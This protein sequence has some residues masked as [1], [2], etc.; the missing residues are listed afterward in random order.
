[1]ALERLL[2]VITLGFSTWVLASPSPDR[3]AAMGISP[4][5]HG[6]RKATY[7][8]AI[9][10]SQYVAVRDGTRLAVD[11]YRPSVS[12]KA[13]ERPFP[14]ILVAS[15]FGARDLKDLGPLSPFLMEILKRGYVIA[16]VQT[17]GHGASFGKAS[18]LRIE[19]SEDYWDLY[20]VI[21]W[22]A[23][24]PW[25]DA[26]VGMAGC[27]NQGVTQFRAASVMPPHL[28]AIAPTSAPV[29]WV[30]LGS[31]N[32]VTTSLFAKGEESGIASSPVDNDRDGR[33]LG[34]ALLEHRDWGEARVTRPYRDDPVT[35]S[36]INLLPAQ[37]WNFL[38][39]FALAKI[40]VFQYTGWRDLFPEQTLALYRSLARLGGVPQK[41]VIGPWYH[42]EWYESSLTDAAAEFLRWYD[43][44]LKGI[45]NGLM[46]DAP[47]RYYVVGAP[48]G[49]EWRTAVRWPLPDAKPETYF[50]ASHGALKLEAA[51]VSESSDSYVVQYAETTAGLA[52]RWNIGKGLP[53]GKN[54]GQ[55]PIPTS[56]LDAL[57]L[58]YTTEP[59]EQDSELTGF[60]TVTLW[61]SSTAK[62]QDFFVYLEEVDQFGK[63]TLLTDGSIRAS[64]RATREPPFENERLPWH[65][66]YKR[67][68]E[69]L[70]PGMPTKLEWALFPFSN[71]VKRGHRVRIAINSFD[72]GAWDSPE[73]SP[74]PVVRISR[75]AS[76]PSSITLPFISK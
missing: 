55:L 32:G 12:G 2:C 47:I 75:D 64:N 6:M 73:I 20:D 43:Y 19:T 74:A 66:S 25:S 41:L 56:A 4:D 15:L 50:L 35:L 46:H 68:Q 5:V 72:K 26:N 60:P 28:K 29:D 9:R 42:C 11:I 61:V 21:E 65:P 17:R 40:P 7:T 44:W 24:Q 22:L 48:L 54:P 16:S 58:I 8:D 51:K 37:W 33:T 14:V 34:A 27:S 10:A 71:Y 45:E 52:T 38:P 39:N 31:I 23:R 1:M 18:P 13:V 36:G 62:D 3:P 57:S 63:S 53:N 49:H 76:H 67:D 70:Q 30:A 69:N 59:L